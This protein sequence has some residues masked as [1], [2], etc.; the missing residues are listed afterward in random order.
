VLSAFDIFK[1]AP[2][3]NKALIEQFAENADSSGRYV[4]TFTTV[5]DH[6]LVSGIEIQ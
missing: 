4:I 3:Q 6:S 5:V 2:G 1:T